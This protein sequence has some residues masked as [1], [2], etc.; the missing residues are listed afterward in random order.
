MVIITAVY[1]E[2]SGCPAPELLKPCVCEDNGI[3][4]GGHSDIDLVNIFQTLEKYLT[5]S[6]KHFKGF[7]LN[8]TF[9]T[10]LKE[11][12]FKDITFDEIQ[13]N[14][15]ENLTHIDR[16][17]FNSTDLVTKYFVL[18]LNDKLI[19]DKTIYDILS[20]FLNIK[21][22]FINGIGFKEIPSNAFRPING[23]QKNL[24]VLEILMHITKIGSHAFSI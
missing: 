6:E 11:N 20:S 14:V 3:I 12:T 23:Y 17:A 2:S 10:E 1:C 15:C 22:I 16:F 18:Q 19:M 24:R 8:N 13:I 21:N 5:K 9:I 4:C 7:H